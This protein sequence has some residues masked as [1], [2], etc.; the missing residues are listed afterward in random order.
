MVGFGQP[1]KLP[2]EGPLLQKGRTIVHRLL[3]RGLVAR[4]GH[5]RQG[6]AGGFELGGRE[7]EPVVVERGAEARH[8]RRVERLDVGVS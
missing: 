2:H 1:G 7:V 4:H 8:E 6:D 3:L 5:A